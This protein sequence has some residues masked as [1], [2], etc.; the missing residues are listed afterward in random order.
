MW[1]WL[2]DLA[3]PAACLWHRR[4]LEKMA[5]PSRVTHYQSSP[6]HR[7]RTRGACDGGRTDTTRRHA[8]AIRARA[9]TWYVLGERV[10]LAEAAHRPA[11]VIAA[12]LRVPEGDAAL[13]NA[14]SI[15]GVPARICGACVLEGRNR[16]RRNRAAT[17]R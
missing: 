6:G 14:R 17:R 11:H 13:P 10:R 15:R 4:V 5:H 16:Q 7:R 8:P 9:V 2:F 1:L 3:E 12:G